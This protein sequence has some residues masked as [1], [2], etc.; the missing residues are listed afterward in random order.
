MNCPI[1]N[2][3]FEMTL[4]VPH[5]YGLCAGVKDNPH[6][7]R[8]EW[9]TLYFGGNKPIEFLPI[10]AEILIDNCSVV[11]FYENDDPK[12]LDIVKEGI[13]YRLT[14]PLD[15]QNIPRLIN[16]ILENTAFI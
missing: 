9:Y 10:K 3:P 11:I 4:D 5:R 7:V 6:I 13:R 16:A 15:W 2:E 12:F 14:S 8:H 1:C